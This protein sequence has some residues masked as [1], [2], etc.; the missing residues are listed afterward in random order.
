MAE[1]SQILILARAGYAAPKNG[2][3]EFHHRISD[4]DLERGRFYLEDFVL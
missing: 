3:P 2:S 4:Q 1:A